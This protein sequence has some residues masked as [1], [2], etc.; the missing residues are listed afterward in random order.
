MRKINLI[1]I[2]IVTLITS[3]FTF[4]AS[5]NWQVKETEYS[6]KFTTKKAEGTIK[7][8]R[9]TINFDESNIKQSNF[10][11]TVDVNTLNT[12][13]GLKNKHAKGEKF[14]V[15]AKHPTIRFTSSEISKSGNTYISKGKLTIKDVT[16]ELE[17]PFSFESKE[18][19]AMFKGNFNISRKDYN[20][21]YMGLSEDIIKL[22]LV[23]PVIKK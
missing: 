14:L 7:G 5:F 13:N 9:G 15:A 11:I 2:V 17:I 21:D 18:N 20:L 19:E 16:K 22:E 8:L 10:D 6:I 1:A 3:A 12:G 23:I 4:I